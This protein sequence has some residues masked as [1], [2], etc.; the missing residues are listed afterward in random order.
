MEVLILLI[1]SCLLSGLMIWTI[2]KAVMLSYRKQQL[3]ISK[4]IFVILGMVVFSILLAGVL[5]YLYFR[6][7]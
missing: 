3:S 7:L 4:A 6:F 5:P 2:V 1:G